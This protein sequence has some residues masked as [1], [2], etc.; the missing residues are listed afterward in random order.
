MQKNHFAKT[1]CLHYRLVARCS[2][3]M[4][5]LVATCCMSLFSSEVETTASDS[6]EEGFLSRSL[7][8]SLARP[9]LGLRGA[10]LWLPQIRLNIRVDQKHVGRQS[11]SQPTDQQRLLPYFSIWHD[12]GVTKQRLVYF[13]GETVKAKEACRSSLA[14]MRENFVYLW[15][16]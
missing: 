6:T 12:S 10:A 7:P 16:S 1:T 3:Y 5:K 8:V 13:S 15:N 14:K 4:Y 2:D 9:C 11:E